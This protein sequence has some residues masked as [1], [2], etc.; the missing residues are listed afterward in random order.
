VRERERLSRMSS[1]LRLLRPRLCDLLLLEY[2]TNDRE[3]ERVRLRVREDLL[4]ERLDVT[5]KLRDLVLG[6]RPPVAPVPP[7]A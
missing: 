4:L 3:R 7:L 1:L 5:E 2:D 6:R